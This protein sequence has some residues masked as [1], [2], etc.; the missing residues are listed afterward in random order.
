MLAS[1]DQGNFGSFG[2]GF[3]ELSAS[4]VEVGLELVDPSVVFT[5]GD[6]LGLKEGESVRVE[7]LHSGD[8]FLNFLER[9]IADYGRNARFI[10]VFFHFFFGHKSFIF[11]ELQRRGGA[12]AISR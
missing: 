12:E 7:E 3:V 9:S 10:F 8:F 6:G 5:E 1:A 2:K 11:N 4:L